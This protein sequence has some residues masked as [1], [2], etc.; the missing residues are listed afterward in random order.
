M[1]FYFNFKSIKKIKRISTIF[2]LILIIFFSYLFYNIISNDQILLN[3]INSL[4]INRVNLFI[5]EGIQSTNRKTSVIDA[6]QQFIKFPF[7]GTGRLYYKEHLEEE[8]STHSIFGHL[9]LFGVIGVFFIFLHVWYLLFTC[10][11]AKQK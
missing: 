10:F 5:H 3:K 11:F 7:F 1:F 6:F 2:L 8:A 4:S 9:L